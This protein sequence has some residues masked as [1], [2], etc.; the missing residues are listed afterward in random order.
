[1]KH[2]A[3]HSTACS[4]N[5][6]EERTKNAHS[7][8]CTTHILSRQSPS[9]HVQEDGENHGELLR[10]QSHSQSEALAEAGPPITILQTNHQEEHEAAHSADHTHDQHHSVGLLLKRTLLCLDFRERLANLAEKSLLAD[11]LHDSDTLSGG[12]HG[13]CGDVNRS[14]KREGR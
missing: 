13:T 3:I 10:Q 1:M 6:K 11:A 2:D 5:K 9:A 12:D 14:K 4:S 8:I 7:T